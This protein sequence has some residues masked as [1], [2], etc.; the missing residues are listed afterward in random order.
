MARFPA[1]SSCETHTLLDM[2]TSTLNAHMSISRRWLLGAVALTG[3]LTAAAL[4]A[5]VLEIPT[6]RYPFLV[7]A[8]TGFL[9]VA[10]LAGASR[11]TYGRLI[12]AGLVFCWLGDVT[13]PYHFALGAGMFLLAHLVFVGAFV[14]Y[15]L[16]L[17]ACLRS[18][19]LVLPSGA[20]L[21]WL[22]PQVEP[23]MQPLVVAY[24]T[25]I[26]A[27]LV[28]AGG[29]SRLIFAAA[30]VFYV[31]DIFVARWRFVDHDSW[32]AFV[33]YPL[34]YTACLMFALSCNA[35]LSGTKTN[36]AG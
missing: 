24:T 16:N 23:S 7:A 18:L 9:V 36:P 28:T 19:V 13:G 22:L 34:Y 15:G 5:P 1:S 30:V 8:S 3:I 33:C 20:I 31:S 29:T 32:N 17:Q 10:W 2:T 25:V 12:L 6:G 11:N 35:S 14:A 27:M 21:W 4:L 26:T